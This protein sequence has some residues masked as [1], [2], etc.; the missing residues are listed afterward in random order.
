MGLK[1]KRVWSG[2]AA[3]CV[4]ASAGAL[5]NAPAAYALGTLA[6]PATVKSAGGAA[7]LYTG[8][9]N[10]VFTLGLP[11]SS[12]CAGDSAN[13]G[14]FVQS[15]IVP[16]AVDPATLTF[17]N[18]GPIPA[19]TGASLRQPMYTTTGS[20]YVDQLT[21]PASPAPGP[22]PI[23]NIPNF[24]YNVY[25]P[26]DIP[27]G[28]Y[29]IGIACTQGSPS[30][31]QLKTFYNTQMV[32]TTNAGG[33]PAQVTFTVGAVPAAPTL[34][35]VTPGDAQL[36]AAF[37]PAAV[38]PIDP[39]TTGYTATATPTPSG[40][41]VTAS[42][43]TSPIVIPGLTNGTT[44]NVTVR[45]T[46]L[47]G[48]SAES[49]VVS[50]TPVP[51][52]RPP[53][54][55]L[56]ATAGAPGSGSATLAWTTPTGPA[57][58]GYQVVVNGPSAGTVGPSNPLPAGATGATVTGLTP[59]SYTFTVTPLHPAPFV[60]TSATSNSI[61]MVSS[62]VLIQDVTVTRPTGAIVLTQ[63]CGKH[64]AIPA[65]TAGTIGFPTGSLP[66]IGA[67]AAGTAPTTGAAPGG[68]A[69]PKF[70]EYPYPE[71]PDGTPNATY[72]THCGIDLGVAKLIKNGPGRGQ[73]FATSGVLN[74]VT[75][76]DTRDTDTG[77]GI[78]G[79]MGTF[80]KTGDATK[81]FSGS[82]LGWNPVMTDD[83]DPF[84][85]SEGTTYDQTVVA[86]AVVNPNSPNA[87]GLSTGKTLGSA[88]GLAG[89]AP[90]FTGGLGVADLDARLKLLI[91]ITEVSGVYTG[92][93][94]VTVA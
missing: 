26:G 70:A 69:D 73:F 90:T 44:Y 12:A 34:N 61:S 25:T 13:D 84:T 16:A 14:Y 19:G 33:G 83:T 64:G 7:N 48:N 18:N 68:P 9:S 43:A 78:T 23:I 51:G 82:Q 77:W 86:G 60:A 37:T 76:V 62:T 66:A 4:A 10:T 52:L 31:T 91:P 75:V 3:L 32:F 28:A 6:G 58:T 59:G 11:A 46:N 72:P 5:I 65:D 17:D 8:D 30:A 20:P 56:T 88:A 67:V 39:P 35:T 22:G 21:A 47:H 71:N 27:A 79:T 54:T 15:Y 93:L 41:P 1:S 74:Q 42:G 92:V 80:T 45:A 87:S 89:S 57:P 53:V 40:A 38:P 36:S 85:D 24:T 55:G 49:N 29:N 63:V 81:T 50:G 94:T 2:V